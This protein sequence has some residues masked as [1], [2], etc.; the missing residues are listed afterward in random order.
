MIDA[1]SNEEEDL[2]KSSEDKFKNIEK[3]KKEWYYRPVKVEKNQNKNALKKDHDLAIA[4]ISSGKTP[5][6]QNRKEIIEK[7][8]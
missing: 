7:E 4:I 6:G 3:E 5:H 1:L 8:A 2:K